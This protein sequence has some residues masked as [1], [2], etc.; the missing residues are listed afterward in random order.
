MRRSFLIP[1]VSSSRHFSVS[2]LLG[3]SSLI[4]FTS[5]CPAP[6]LAVDAG[7][8]TGTDAG[9]PLVAASPDLQCPGSASC[10]QA[11]SDDGL[12]VG[13]AARLAM[14]YGFEVG[15]VQYLRNSNPN[16]CPPEQRALFPNTPKCG[17]L[18]DSF[19][20]DCGNDAVCFSDEGYV[21][22]D[23]DGSESD[24]QAIDWFWDCGRDRI[25]PPPFDTPENGEFALNGL[26]DDG[27]GAIDEGAYTGPDADGTEGNG[28]FD[29]LWL[30]GY[31]NNRPALGVKDPLWARAVV[32]KQGDAN[33][34]IVH[35]DA[36]GLFYNEE[37]E[38]RRRVEEL[39]PDAI[40]L[41]ILQ[42]SHSHETPDTMGQWGLFDPYVGLPV[43]TGRDP[44]HIEGIRQGA[45]D[46][47][48]AALDSVQPV[49]MR[50]GAVDTGVSGFL[51]DSRD[52]QVMN[53]TLTVVKFTSTG[54]GSTV[55]TLVNW[56]NHPESLDSD[57][58]FVSSDYLHTLREGLE[59]GMP[60]TVR[61]PERPALGGVAIY[62]QG[63]VGGLI[64]PNGFLITGRDGTTYE[65]SQKT[66]AR[67]DAYGYL[68]AEQAFQALDLA[69][70]VPTPTL[71][72]ATKKYQ[73]PVE[74]VTFHVISLNGLIER[75][76]EDFNPDE[77][78]D[79]NNIP[80][81]SSEVSVVH[82][83]PVG[84]VTAPGELFP[85]L[86]LGFSDEHAGDR[87]IVDPNNPNPPDL[88]QA[89]AAPYLRELVGAS[90][91]MILGL[92]HDE[93]GYLVPPYDFKLD[94]QAPYISQPE[95]DHYEETNSIGPQAVPKMLENLDILF[96]ALR[97]TDE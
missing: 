11:S 48:I 53:D 40:D 76:F 81:T 66:F 50:V 68:L 31:D 70:D 83:G 21:G 61:F 34:A 43:V 32:M 17:T 72:F 2:T 5:A 22:P 69:Q 87:P 89:P 88:S 24:G 67:T 93:M 64:G 20:D 37:E 41:I 4:I 86:F 54:D 30:A 47:I 77:P 12:Q 35:V 16:D 58:N 59:K 1:S 62:L 51:H 90:Y 82:V 92:A 14:P 96:K 28:L 73:I 10:V 13:A 55:A 57:N 9:S 65:S 95:G 33:I 49:T 75:V 45:T 71:T 19:L 8:D 97:S 38:I 56:S 36:V 26:D 15:K 18:L 6:N 94:E 42:S 74:N 80:K 85:E 27:D 39:R 7:T 52:P 25:C 60:A 91:P 79:A 23:A 63:A 78:I 44:A 29:G 3:T 46:A 84:M